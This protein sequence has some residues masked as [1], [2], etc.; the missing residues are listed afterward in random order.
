MPIWLA[1]IQVVALNIAESQKEYTKEVI[2]ILKKNGIRCES[3]LRNEK[4]TYKIRE[5][6]IQRIPYLVVL[7]DREVEKTQVTVRT[8]KGEDL[9]S[10]SIDG[11]IAHLKKDIESRV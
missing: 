5:H 10:M 6:S 2:E 3:D 1:P 9:G 7:G 8:Q 4:I 11:F